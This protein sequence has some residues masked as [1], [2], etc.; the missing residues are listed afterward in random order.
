M[1]IT[2]R[3]EGDV[4]VLTLYGRLDLASGA[5]MKEAAKMYFADN[6]TSLLLNLSGVEF[7]NSS[8][9]GALVSV[10]KEVRV[11]KGRLSL[12]DLDSFVQELLD[13]TQL[14]QIF[15]IFPTEQEALASYQTPTTG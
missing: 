5:K 8:G 7:V 3:Q 11:L 1:E 6:K 12:S 4:I 13:I 14:S 2:D 15:E 9:L 10:M